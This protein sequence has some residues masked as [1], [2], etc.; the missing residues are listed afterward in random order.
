[1]GSKF[2]KILAHIDVVRHIDAIRNRMSQYEPPL[3]FR[4]TLIG[5]NYVNSRIY[6][7]LSVL[8]LDANESEELARTVPRVYGGDSGDDGDDEH[9]TPVV[10]NSEMPAKARDAELISPHTR[11]LFAVNLR[12]A[13][14]STRRLP[15]VVAT[16]AQDQA[17]Q[18][19]RFG[20]R[21]AW[22]AEI[23]DPILQS[24]W[25]YIDE[26]LRELEDVT[27][28]NPSADLQLQVETAARRTEQR[29]LKRNEDMY[30][31]LFQYGRPGKCHGPSV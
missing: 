13:C 7:I 14:T 1:M 20:F 12:D 17:R 18:Y 30:Q 2:L 22:A 10:V 19:S 6:P 24:R 31:A 21:G 5:I 25:D 9:W 8:E 28:E 3:T 26:T 15:P 23:G 27:K 11:T 29:A 4:N 16:K